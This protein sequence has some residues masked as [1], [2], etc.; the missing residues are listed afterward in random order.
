MEYSR[1]YLCTCKAL[2]ASVHPK[3]YTQECVLSAQVQTATAHWYSPPQVLSVV[4]ICST[5]KFQNLSLKFIPVTDSGCPEEGLTQGTLTERVSTSPVKH[6]SPA[7][8]QPCI[9]GTLR[10]KWYVHVAFF[11][12]IFTSPSPITPINILWSQC[13]IGYFRRAPPVNVPTTTYR[14][15]QL[16]SPAVSTH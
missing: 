14:Q 15:K 4:F 6:V 2:K 1:V 8:S 7:F 16:S 12:L 13:F 9:H 10:G 5:L 11:E 3:A